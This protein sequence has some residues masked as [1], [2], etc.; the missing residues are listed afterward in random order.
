MMG[1]GTTIITIGLVL[2]AVVSWIIL[3]AVACRRIY[4]PKDTILE[5]L[6]GTRMLSGYQ[7]TNCTRR[8]TLTAV[9]D[10]NFD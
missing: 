3:V 6:R 7:Y 9:T 1:E 8:D 2:V 5:R 10:Y 4:R